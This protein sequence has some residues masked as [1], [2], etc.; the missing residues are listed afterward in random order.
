MV[1]QQTIHDSTEPTTI[2][3]IRSTLRVV[4]EE[5][6]IPLTLAREYDIYS[7]AIYDSN[8]NNNNSRSNIV[9]VA[10]V[11][12]FYIY[13]G[14]CGGGVV[15]FNNSRSADWRSILRSLLY[16]TNL[17]ITTTGDD[18][19]TTTTIII[20]LILFVLTCPSIGLHSNS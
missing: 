4:E 14:V 11:P 17:S 6:G 20:I 8:N 7:M 12:S 16:N 3:T 5:G 13:V 9:S 15:S 10:T 19:T 2:Y 1:G 18:T